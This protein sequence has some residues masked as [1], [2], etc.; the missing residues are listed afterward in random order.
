MSVHRLGRWP[1]ITPTLGQRLVFAGR[2]FFHND[3]MPLAE[4]TLTLRQDI[5]V[6]QQALY[7]AKKAVVYLRNLQVSRCCRLALHSSV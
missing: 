5:H 6:S 1:N 7:K 4:A 3:S 2:P